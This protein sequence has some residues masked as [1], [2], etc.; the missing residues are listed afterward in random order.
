MVPLSLRERKEAAAR[1]GTLETYNLETQRDIYETF[2]PS[3]D[4]AGIGQEPLPR[5]PKPA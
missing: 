4:P 2:A 1:S 5:A 3:R